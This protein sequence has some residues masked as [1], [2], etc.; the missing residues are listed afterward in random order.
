[1]NDLIDENARLKS[2]INAL[3]AELD[4]FKEQNRS[5]LK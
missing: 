4:S 1:M 5:Y 2:R 3:E